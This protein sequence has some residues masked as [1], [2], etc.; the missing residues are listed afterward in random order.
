MILHKL[1][2]C[3]KLF[4]GASFETA[5]VVED[6]S[7]QGAKADLIIYIVQ[8]ALPVMRTSE[9]PAKATLRETHL[10]LAFNRLE[11]DPIRAKNRKHSNTTYMAGQ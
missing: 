1:L 4:G 7:R 6:K 2:Y 3:G 9:H 10:A 5:R 11:I 8:T